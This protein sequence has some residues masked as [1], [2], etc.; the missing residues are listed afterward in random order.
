MNRDVIQE[1]RRR[2]DVVIQEKEFGRIASDPDNWASL[3]A[4]NEQE[5][6]RELIAQRGKMETEL[7][8]QTL[9]EVRE[10]TARYTK[11]EMV[12]TLGTLAAVG[13]GTA[14]LTTKLDE[15]K[16]KVLDWLDAGNATSG[17]R[18]DMAPVNKADARKA[19]TR[20]RLKS[21][22]PTAKKGYPKGFLHG[23]MGGA[24]LGGLLGYGVG[25]G[26]GAVS[27]AIRGLTGG[28]DESSAPPGAGGYPYR[29]G[30]PYG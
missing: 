10:N 3:N 18:A 6:M 1:L 2:S 21:I 9:E 27:G 29:P 7:Y 23:T 17:G 19:Q 11:A 22:I 14:Y 13:G 25:R 30:G 12:A 24:L 26:V 4:R 28:G 16:A 15:V 20:S 5:A 8:A